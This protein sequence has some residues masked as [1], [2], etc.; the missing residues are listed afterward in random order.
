MSLN[1]SYLDLFVKA[2]EFAAYGASPFIGKGD[3]NAADQGAVDKM[4]SELNIID[5]DGTV[6]IGEGEMD[7]AP[8]LFIGEK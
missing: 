5:M 1:K 2:T 4:R 8:M 6:V 3:K 7:E